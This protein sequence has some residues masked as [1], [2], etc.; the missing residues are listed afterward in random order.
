MTA[1]PVHKADA[2]WDVGVF[3]SVAK[4]KLALGDTAGAIPVYARIAVDP[5]TPAT[6]ADSIAAAYPRAYNA[7]QWRNYTSAGVAFLKSQLMLNATTRPARG[8]FHLTDGAGKSSVFAGAAP[9]ET[10]VAV[11]SRHCPPSLMQLALV[12]QLTQRM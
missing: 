4:T 1:K 5:L 8:D 11:W 3:R 10:F 6:F 7:A 2:T 9:S 12:Q